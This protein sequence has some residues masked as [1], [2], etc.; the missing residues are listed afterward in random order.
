MAVLTGWDI[1]EEVIHVSNNN[2]NA[3]H[4]ET[5]LPLREVMR[6]SV[7][8]VQ[9]EATA[10]EAAQKM[11][12]E[13]VGSCIVLQKNKPTGIVTEE[14]LSCK[15]VA[16]NLLPSDVRVNTIMS[17]P[18]ITIDVGKTVMDAAHMMV[19]HRVRRL[20][21][22]EDGQVIGIVTVRDLFSVA[23][24][25]NEIMADLVEIR[26]HVEMD[27]GVCDGCGAMA[28]DLKLV[29]NRMLCSRCRWEDNLL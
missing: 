4:F 28:D 1:F 22:M 25:M 3:G 9:S 6:H 2:L 23:S 15:L 13:K 16:K 7:M 20:P 8:T 11:C 19:S 18:L 24:E 5:R 17:T 26:S 10:D 29:D 14:D 27:A 12:A 21:V